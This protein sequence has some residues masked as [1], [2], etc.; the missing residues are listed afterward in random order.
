MLDG[1]WGCWDGEASF[2]QH[3]LCA[4]ATSGCTLCQHVAAAGEWGRG[5]VQIV[6]ADGGQADDEQHLE[7]KAFHCWVH[8]LS[9]RKKNAPCAGAG[10]GYSVH[11]DASII[12]S[13]LRAK[14][15]RP[16]APTGKTVVPWL[17]A[18]KAPGGMPERH[19]TENRLACWPAS[20]D[21]RAIMFPARYY[22]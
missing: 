9:A 16:G 11:A 2:A 7:E 14:C 21:S 4:S 13:A 19:P 22:N 20:E 1:G 8:W 18:G 15:S 3:P 17:L 5:E 12:G 6:R 10:G